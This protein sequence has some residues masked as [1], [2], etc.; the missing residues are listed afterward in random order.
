M[1]V[2]SVILVIPYIQKNVE[3]IEA[4]DKAAVDFMSKKNTFFTQRTI[5]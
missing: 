3:C 5:Y 4:V 1:N 2:I